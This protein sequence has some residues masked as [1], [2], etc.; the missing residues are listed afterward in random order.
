MMWTDPKAWKFD[1]PRIPMEDDIVVID[2]DMNIVYDVALGDEVKLRSLE[3]NGK[4][5][6]LDGADREIKSYSVWV[7]A[8]E[9]NIGSATAPC[10]SQAT[11]TLLGDNTE[12]YWS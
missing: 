11:I 7:R 1:P 2:T 6:F 10:Q 12:Y 8:G 4:L 5:T 3:V 9:L